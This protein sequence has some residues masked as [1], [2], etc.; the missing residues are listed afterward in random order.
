MITLP[1]SARIALLSA[2]T[3]AIAFTAQPLDARTVTIPF[4]PSNFSDPLDIDNAYFPLVPITTFTYR[5]A[6]PDGCE[7][8]ITTVTDTT[9]PIAGVTTRVV[10]DQAF[11]G[12]TCSDVELVE[13]T[14]DYYAQDNAGNVWYFG[15]DT[16]DCEGAGNCTPGEG[17]WRAGVNGA[18]PGIIM[19]ANPRSGDSY[20]QELSPGIAED[21][22]KVTAVGV[23]E[24][25]TRSDAFRRSYSNCIVT[26][27]WTELERGAIEF[28][29]YCPNIGNVLTVE[30]HGKIVR[31]EL[32][33]I[34]GTASALKFRTVPR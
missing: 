31:S 9:E 8:T 7:V 12:E 21:Q 5:A 22:A 25:M 17:A 23:T 19:L 1:T 2:T 30:H 10:H 33:S 14:F 13:D 26:K 34:S 16:F 18:V 15:E 29:T 6:T 3:L 4:S 27:E 32:V 20:R 28:K 24:K 11:D